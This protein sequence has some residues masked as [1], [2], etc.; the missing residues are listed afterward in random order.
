MGIVVRESNRY[1]AQIGKKSAKWR[2][3]VRHNLSPRIQDK[4]FSVSWIRLARHFIGGKYM[5]R[6]LFCA[7]PRDCELTDI[8]SRK[9]F[10]DLTALRI[11]NYQLSSCVGVENLT[12]F[13]SR[14]RQ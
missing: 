9:V 3:E 6:S 7:P 10:G 1:T 13:A 11:L 2:L 4:E 14:R 5:S 8:A 12:W